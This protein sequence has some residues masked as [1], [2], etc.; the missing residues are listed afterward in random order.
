MF[1]FVNNC[2]C[3]IIYREQSLC[4]AESI[5]QAIKVRRNKKTYEKQ[6]LETNGEI[7][8]AN[9]KEKVWEQFPSLN[10][11]GAEILFSNFSQEKLNLFS[12]T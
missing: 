3:K 12:D 1:L 9:D 7:L 2:S 11:P 6:V 5:G 8:M 10:F 4:V